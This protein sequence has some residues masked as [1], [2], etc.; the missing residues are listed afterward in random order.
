MFVYVIL[1]INKWRQEF[2][3]RYVCYQNEEIEMEFV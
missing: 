1:T 2:V 3:Y